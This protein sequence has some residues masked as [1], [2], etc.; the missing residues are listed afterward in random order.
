M[1]R[2]SLALGLVFA[3]L[4]GL[5]HPA[6]RALACSCAGPTSALAA[7]EHAEVVFSGRVMPFDEGGK[8]E[9]YRVWKGEVPATVPVFLIG[10]N[11][12]CFFSFDEGEEYLVFV[13][14]RIDGLMA[15]SIC[16]GTAELGYAQEFLDELGPGRPPQPDTAAVSTVLLVGLATV[17]VLATMGPSLWRRCS[18]WLRGRRGAS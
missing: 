3:L 18:R 16:S 10:P 2:L 12:I 9:V 1:K 14:D 5:A 8:F 11:P 6:E 7:T 15:S 4:V 17:V 13:T